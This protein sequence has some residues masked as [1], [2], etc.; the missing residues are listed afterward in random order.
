MAKDLYKHTC[1]NGI[2]VSV[3]NMDSCLK[4]FFQWRHLYFLK[5]ICIYFVFNKIGTHEKF[6]GAEMCDKEGSHAGYSLC[7]MV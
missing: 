2:C 3:L 5:C 6:I 1:Y 4:Y 7:S